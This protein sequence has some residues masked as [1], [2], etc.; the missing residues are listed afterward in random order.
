MTASIGSVRK[1]VRDLAVFAA[2]IA[3]YLLLML[4]VL[5]KLGFST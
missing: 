4:V 2:A 5:P 3:L 1:V